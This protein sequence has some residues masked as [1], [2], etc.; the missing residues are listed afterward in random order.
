MFTKEKTMIQKTNLIFIITFLFLFSCCLDSEK[1]LLKDFVFVKGAKIEGVITAEGY[2]ESTIFKAGATHDVKDFYICNHEVTQAE[3][4]RYY[5]GY[6]YRIEE[7][8]KGI[9]ASYPAYD[10]NWFDTLVYCNN[11]SIAEGLTPCY[12]INGSTN[13]KDWGKV[14]KSREWKSWNDWI[15]AECD[16]EA[17]GYRLPTT[18]EWEYA[19]RGGNGLTG[20]QYKYAGSD[21]LDEVAWWNTDWVREVKKKKPNT[22]GI[23]DMNGNLDEWC[24][25][26]Y[27]GDANRLCCGGYY[28]FKDEKSYL[29]SKA[30]SMTLSIVVRNSQLGF[31]VVRSK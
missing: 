2:T 18:T 30:P 5:E 3:F 21:N 22:L 16:F 10:V 12:T 11:R 19:A 17:D 29:L 13:P 8:E 25:E 20:Y 6:N 23:Y 1:D 4:A 27:K 31:R 7:N 26:R 24:W 14:P 15:F 28:Y 9:G